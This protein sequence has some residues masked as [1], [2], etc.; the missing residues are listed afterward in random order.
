MIRINYHDHRNNTGL[1]NKLFLNFLARALSIENSEPLENWLRTEIY[2][3]KE[4]PYN[5]VHYDRWGFAWPHTNQN[6][7]K[8]T[9]VGKGANCGYGDKYH[10]NERTIEIISKHKDSLIKDFG[11]RPEG[12]CL[13][14]FVHARFGD[15]VDDN[16]LNDICTYEYYTLC[17][18]GLGGGYIASDSLDHP[19]VKALCNN[20]GLKPYNGTPEETIIF[21]SQFPNKILSLGTFSWWIGFIGSQNNVMYPNPN[22]YRRW[23]G[24][25]FECM[26]DWKRIDDPRQMG[27]LGFD[28]IKRINTLTRF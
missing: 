9:V 14:A 5:G 24:P 1:G 7:S 27:G 13:Q 23:H 28:N 26:Q 15:L 6:D 11:E 8:V 25:I 10:Q 17:L 21:G 22:E 3:G 19:I 18:S 4:E 20:F 12:D 16:R 2:A